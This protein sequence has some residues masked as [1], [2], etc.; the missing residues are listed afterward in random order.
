MLARGS[1]SII[2][3]HLEAPEIHSGGSQVKTI[4]ILL[5]KQIHPFHR[6]DICMDGA[7]AMGKTAGDLTSTQ[8]VAPG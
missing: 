3:G 7:K 1:Q 6:V 8:A 5:L 4:F 2:H